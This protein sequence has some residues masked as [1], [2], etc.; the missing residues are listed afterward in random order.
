[1][2]KK[3]KLYFEQLCLELAFYEN[4]GINWIVLDLRIGRPIIAL[5]KHFSENGIDFLLCSRHNILK[6]ISDEYHYNNLYNYVL[7]LSNSNFFDRLIKS[8]IDYIKNIA[9]YIYHFEAY[10]PFKNA[11][12]D[13]KKQIL[14]K[15]Y[16][17]YQNAYYHD[18]KREDIRDY[19]SGLE[20]EI[21]LNMII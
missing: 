6:P 10:D 18:I 5:M 8:K 21:K 12:N 17:Y 7:S 11:F 16:D 4:H 14:N 2:I 15:S 3:N 20:R 13:A 19:V 9:D 1:V